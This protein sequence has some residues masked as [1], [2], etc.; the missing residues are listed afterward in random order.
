MPPITPFSELALL[1]MLAAGLGTLGLFLR[2]PL[3]V[4]F[5][6]VGLIAGPS[7][8][9]LVHSDEQ[10]RVLSELGIALLLFLVGIKLDIKLLRSF[11][12]VAVTSG[13]AQVA[14]TFALGL[15]AG[16]GLGLGWMTSLYVALGLAFSSTIIIV[17]LLSDRREIDAL[18]GQIALGF[19]IV[20][21]LVV[22][23]TMILLSATGLAGADGGHGSASGPVTLSLGV[24]LFAGVGLFARSFAGAVTDL[25]ARIPELLVLFA[26]ALAAAVAAIAEAAGLGK[27]LGGLLA[28]VALAST[29]Y[30]ETIAA[31]LAPLR[32]FLLL[33]FFIAL[34]AGIDL[35]QLGNDIG[36]ALTLSLLVLVGKPVLVIAI[37]IA[38]GY[39]RRTAFLAGVTM[40]Q[41]S[42]FSLILM[43]MGVSLGHVSSAELGL[44]T[45][46][47]LIT[48]AVSTYMVTHGHR[49]YELCEP[50]LNRLPSR[51]AWRE[52]DGASGSGRP[53]VIVLGLGRFGTA[54]GLRLHRRGVRVLGID[55][56][57]QAVR[58]W[59]MLGI[60]AA[61]G[62]AS[63]A[64]FLADLPLADAEWLVSTAPMH[65]TGL[66]HDDHRLA[67]I[68]LARGA[69]FS[70][71]IAVTSHSQAETEALT[72]AGAHLVLEPFQDAADRAVELLGGA[73]IEARTEIPEIDAEE[74]TPP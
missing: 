71:R 41:I 44:V 14:L 39:G 15:C 46:V 1:L 45:L 65:A 7:A 25:L 34:G 48:I 36:A 47:G 67:L 5:I 72:A 10:I 38:M 20:Q 8:L 28:G 6:A 33:F 63:D 62:D 57:P 18:H 2:Q 70:G 4:A 55:F 58:R 50:L 42:E 31:R 30:R 11:G 69:G 16:L 54:L 24:A 49:L 68:Q 21:D 59:R 12:A 53:Q 22:V 73:R 60:E 29:S 61:Y 64:E 32:D 19:L 51:M 9:D 66:S 56:N 43:A 35:S 40:G 13:L 26:L 3:I 37:L 74:R 27:E 52:P 23:V 17:K